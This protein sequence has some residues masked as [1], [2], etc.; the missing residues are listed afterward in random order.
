MSPETKKKPLELQ[1]GSKFKVKSD[2]DGN[3]KPP[4][5]ITCP[6]AYKSETEHGQKVMCKYREGNGNPSC[7]VST[8][9]KP[10]MMVPLFYGVWKDKMEIQFTE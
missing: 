5:L 6:Y 10:P 3:I 9:G 1:V 8:N 4:S 2:E 7:Y